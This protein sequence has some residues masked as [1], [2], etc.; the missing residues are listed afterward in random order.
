MIYSVPD[1]GEQLFRIHV[2]ATENRDG[3]CRT[4]LTAQRDAT[5]IDNLNLDGLAVYLHER[6]DAIEIGAHLAHMEDRFAQ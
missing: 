4:P 2:G 3:E 6:A 5:L 1:I